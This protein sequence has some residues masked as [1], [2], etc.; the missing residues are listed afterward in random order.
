M[1]TK[2]GPRAGVAALIAAVEAEGLDLHSIMV[3]QHGTVLAECYRSP[4]DPDTPHRMYSVTKSFTSTAVGLA[5]A[6]GR[7]SVDDRVIDIFPEL[8]PATP[9]AHRNE[10]R[11]GHLLTMSSG[12]RQEAFPPLYRPLPSLAAFVSGRPS[13]APGSRFDYSNPCSY[14]LAAIVERVTGETISDYLRPR[15]LEPL[16]IACRPWLRSDEGVTNGGFGLHLT[17]RELSRFGQMLLQRGMWE[18]QQLVP[19]AW[20]DEAT[21]R[22]VDSWNAAGKVDWLQ[23]YAY[24]FW[25]GRHGSFRAD[26]LMGQFCIV[27][28][29]RDALV[30][31]TAGTLQTQRL[32]DLVWE[33]VLPALDAPGGQLDDA[34][35]PAFSS[36]PIDSR[37]SS[38]ARELAGVEFAFGEPILLPT[39]LYAGQAP[40]RAAHC[41]I[42][43]DTLSLVLRD[44][45]G[46]YRLPLGQ[47]SWTA[48][49][50]PVCTGYPEP[51]RGRAV[52]TSQTSLAVD[53]VF[54]EAGFR[55]GLVFDLEPVMQVTV[56]QPANPGMEGRK[57]IGRPFP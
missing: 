18:G 43:G 31:T 38:R 19:A 23:G 12:H 3:L 2:R 53:L 1:T 32:L 56:T 46:D 11:V 49:I 22:R 7:L 40:I 8:V 51:C 30:V 34:P 14:T 5:V 28:P 57:V 36:R 4:F 13:V 25:R 41:E 52:W 45:R 55:L 29:E 27:L 35:M 16:G 33:L 10:L 9:D 44:E 17:T 47:A 42:T 15:I 24:Q 54:T 39:R 37:P 20:I 26:G 48:G 6:E 50:T 21:G